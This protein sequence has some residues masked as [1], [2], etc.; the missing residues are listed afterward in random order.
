MDL[1]PPVIEQ[2]IARADRGLISAGNPA[3]RD[4]AGRAGQGAVLPVLDL[5]KAIGGH[6]PSI[7][8][9]GSNTGF[10]LRLW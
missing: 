7:S 8:E 1:T 2:P 4:A 5:P 10:R 6:G 9:A 3:K